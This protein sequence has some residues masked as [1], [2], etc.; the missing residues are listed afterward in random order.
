MLSS[1]VML[2]VVPNGGARARSRSSDQGFTAKQSVDHADKKRL[3]L[4]NPTSGPATG[5]AA[6]GSAKGV[7]G[8]PSS[9]T[10]STEAPAA[11]PSEHEGNVKKRKASTQPA[12]VEGREQPKL[13]LPAAEQDEGHAGTAM[14]AAE[15]KGPAK[16]ART[17]KSK[18][19]KGQQ[20]TGDA[21]TGEY[22][23]SSAETT[24]RVE[25]VHGDCVHKLFSR[26]D[27]LS[28]SSDRASS[29]LTTTKRHVA[30]LHFVALP[31]CP[32]TDTSGGASKRSQ[33]ESSSQ[34]GPKGSQSAAVQAA[35][36]TEAAPQARAGNGAGPSGA[37]PPAAAAE[38]D[39]GGQG[40]GKKSRSSKAQKNAVQRLDFDGLEEPATKASAPVAG[41]RGTAGPAKASAHEPRMAAAAAARAPPGKEGAE[42][43]K[44]AAA[45]KA[46]RGKQR[47]QEA[48]LPS[49]GEP[50]AVVPPP[51]KKTGT[52]TAMPAV[53][54]SG[55]GAVE[56]AGTSA[57]AGQRAAAGAAAVQAPPISGAAAPPP[58]AVAAS[59]PL[60]PT[61]TT[62]FK[63]FAPAPLPPLDHVGRDDRAAVLQLQ[64]QL[65]NLQKMYDDLKVPPGNWDWG[66]CLR[67]PC[68]H[69]CCAGEGRCFEAPRRPIPPPLRPFVVIPNNLGRPH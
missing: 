40:G 7:T 35:G 68:M 45:A 62:P 36:A 69:S 31:S 39:A 8:A 23:A 54:P 30:D 44:A 46:D 17:T 9:H 64:R 47:G 4:P 55:R 57:G 24:L 37:A 1:S 41:Q 11:K 49:A 65:A 14:I 66:P 33:Q 25:S 3:S 61:G 27:W 13:E 32:P 51:A 56:A 10:T 26:D 43:A 52:A 21:A 29:L 60:P 42:E 2:N 67:L 15:G 12:P 59:Q 6:G 63:P 58:L 38:Q 28:A 34:G 16:K 50:V 22:L 18:D 5:A 48:Q 53:E 19:N 20:R